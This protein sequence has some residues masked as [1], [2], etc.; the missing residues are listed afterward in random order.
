MRLFS[1][2]YSLQSKDD[3]YFYIKQYFAGREMR[4]IYKTDDYEFA[5]HLMGILQFPELLI[6][7]TLDHIKK[8][9]N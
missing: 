3:G 1:L 2:T 8:S 9:N 7:T 4:N 6:K 5:L